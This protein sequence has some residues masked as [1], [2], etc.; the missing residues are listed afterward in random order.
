MKGT[1]ILK[2]T[3]EVKD[4]NKLITFN[5]LDA[6]SLTICYKTIRETM[7]VTP[8]QEGSLVNWTIMYEKQKED[9]PPLKE[10]LEVIASITKAVDVYLQNF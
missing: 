9:A 2:E 7:Q 6:V 5:F 4:E 1:K 8:K 3:T 10:Y